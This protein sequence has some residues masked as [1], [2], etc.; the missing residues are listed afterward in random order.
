MKPVTRKFQNS[1]LRNRLIIVLMLIV[2]IPL[3]LLGGI[4]Y[5]SIQQIYSNKIE[6]GITNTLDKVKSGLESTLE[7]ME[8]ASLQLSMEGGVGQDFYTLMTAQSEFQKYAI[9]REIEKNLNLVN[10]TNPFLGV[11]LYYSKDGAILFNNRVVDADF[12]NAPA[13]KLSEMNGVTLYGPRPT[14]YHYEKNEVFALV[15]PVELPSDI[16]GVNQYFVYMET[17]S[18]LFEKLL[19]RQQYGMKVSHVLLNQTGEIVFSDQ[20]AEFPIGE[21][22]A[23]LQQM[24]HSLTTDRYN[25]YKVTSEQG[26]SLIVTINKAEFNQE[27]NNWM[28]KFYAVLGGGIII[29]VLFAYILWQSVYKPIKKIGD[30]MLQVDLQSDRSIVLTGVKEFDVLVR[31]F[32]QMKG[33]IQFLFQETET[34]ERAKRQLEVEKLL[35]QINPHFI[36]NTLNSIQF[37]A[38]M[39]GQ[40]DIDRMVTLFTRVLHYNLEKRGETVELKEELN[41]LRDYIELQQIRYDY[42]F[43]VLFDVDE[44]VTAQTIM[45]PKFIL[46]PLLENALYHELDNDKGLIQIIVSPDSIAHVAIQIVDNGSGMTEEE[47]NLLLSDEGQQNRKTGLGIGL[48]YVRRMLDAHFESEYSFKITSTVGLGTKVAIRIPIRPSLD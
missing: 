2:F 13:N 35:Y 21:S 41:A 36:H 43:S 39:N 33:R 18:Q 17:N 15:R 20:K 38:R 30:D 16:D 26:W 25:L 42:E 47:I 44:Q 10:F 4:S 12:M 7:N 34:R 24:N 9:S 19:S 32:N 8:Y 40:K 6:S 5:L 1:S 22:N 46:Q 14:I 45:I 31:K 11:I 28:L 48:N 27:F 3:S 29:S 37:M 23:Q